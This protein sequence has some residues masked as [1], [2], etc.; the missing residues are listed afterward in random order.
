M[1]ERRKWRLWGKLWKQVDRKI[2]GPLF[3]YLV[4]IEMSDTPGLGV[5]G[6]MGLISAVT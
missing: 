2:S 5:G 3:A 6:A 1:N 4:V